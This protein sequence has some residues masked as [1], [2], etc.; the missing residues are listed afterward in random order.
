[1]SNSTKKSIGVVLIQIALAVMFFVMGLQLLGL[2]GS[3]FGTSEVSDA[4][5]K[6]FSGTTADIVRIV[7]GVLFLIS[8]ILFIARFFWDPGKLEGILRI[9]VLVIWIC[10]VIITDIL[11][12]IYFTAAWLTTI[13]R[14]LLIVGGILAIND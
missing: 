5:K 11:P 1:M 14:D 10:A 9:T 13:S 3:F 6:M 12:G 2:R 7:I 8:G 4:I